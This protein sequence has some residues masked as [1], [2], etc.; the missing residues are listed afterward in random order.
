MEE[1]NTY[2]AFQSR[3][4]FEEIIEILNN[5]GIEFQTEDYPI[6]FI[7][8]SA[9]TSFSHEYLIKLKKGSFKKVDAILEK[10]SEREIKD[11][12][13]NYYLFD[14]NQD[15]LINLLKEQ[16]EWNKFDVTLAKKLLKD[17]GIQLSNEDLEKIKSERIQELSKPE[18]KQSIWVIIGYISSILG[19]LFGIL[20]GWHLMNHKRILPNGERIFDYS[21][22]DRKHGKIIF[23]IGVVMF[24]IGITLRIIL[25]MQNV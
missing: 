12:D 10:L 4:D 21:E 23:L 25:F 20:I 15:E 7:S 2:Q 24:T 5:N 19:G 9:N 16:D 1:F 6:N 22:K 11:V 13:P 17:K 14:F 8:D 18:T 3:E